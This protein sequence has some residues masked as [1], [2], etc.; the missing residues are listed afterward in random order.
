VKVYKEQKLGLAKQINRDYPGFFPDYLLAEKPKVDR[1][2]LTVVY[3][4]MRAQ[5]E[6]NQRFGEPAKLNSQAMKQ[7]GSGGYYLGH[8]RNYVDEEK[9]NMTPTLRR[10]LANFDPDFL[11]TLPN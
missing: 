3:R 11:Y 4:T 2:Q 1:F 5:A 6:F 9:K 7:N 8:W 10:E